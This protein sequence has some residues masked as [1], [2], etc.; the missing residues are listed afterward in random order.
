ML[1]DDFFVGKIQAIAVDNAQMVNIPEL[2]T[3]QLGNLSIGAQS[4]THTIRNE[5]DRP[6][7]IRG[8]ASANESN[9]SGVTFGAP[10]DNPI[11]AQGSTT[12]QIDFNIDAEGAFGFDV[13]ISA[14][15]PR[16]S[17]NAFNYALAGTGFTPMPEIDVQ[18]PAGTSTRLGHARRAG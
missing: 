18:R 8:I 6:L 13:D 2:T 16:L 12:F 3:D 4:I 9:V 17:D 10:V 1:F 14:N 7:T 5:G 15:D 11:P